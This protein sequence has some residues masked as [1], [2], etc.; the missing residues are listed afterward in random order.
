MRTAHWTTCRSFE[1]AASVSAEPSSAAA[2]DRANDHLM[3]VVARLNDL[4]PAVDDRGWKE[5][6]AIL[7][8]ARTSA[9][10]QRLRD[11]AAMTALL[12]AAAVAGLSL[13]AAL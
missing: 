10:R 12:V 2:T 4:A 9:H 13:G 6:D 1:S 5:A 3:F 8:R 7:E 11:A